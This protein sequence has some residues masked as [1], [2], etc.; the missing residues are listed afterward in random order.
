MAKFSNVQ[1]ILSLFSHPSHNNLN[2]F[3]TKQL[4]GKNLSRGYHYSNQAFGARVK[5]T[6]IFIFMKPQLNLPS[7]V[8]YEVKGEMR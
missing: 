4:L 5:I 6:L 8:S 2:I 7:Y 3:W 1:A